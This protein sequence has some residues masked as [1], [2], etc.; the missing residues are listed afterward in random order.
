MNR[1]VSM[2]R[3]LKP[4]LLH[5]SGKALKDYFDEQL[6]TRSGLTVK[7][8]DSYNAAWRSFDPQGY[9]DYRAESAKRIDIRN[10]K[11]RLTIEELEQI[12][13]EKRNEY[14]LFS[15]KKD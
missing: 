15:E 3:E 14:S 11:E 10:A 7:E 8:W 13:Q 2:P 9:A 1:H 5:L 6:K 4:K 12:I